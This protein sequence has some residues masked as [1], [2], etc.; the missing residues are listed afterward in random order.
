MIVNRIYKPSKKRAQTAKRKAQFTPAADSD[1]V[2]AC[3]NRVNNRFRQREKKYCKADI[4]TAAQ[5]RGA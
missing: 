1:V 5:K 2:A 3:V 4:I